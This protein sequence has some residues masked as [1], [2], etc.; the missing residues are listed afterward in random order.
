MK[1]EL[2]FEKVYPHPIERVWRA[3][4]EREALGSWLM[5]TDFVASE[6]HAF[7]MWCEDGEGGTDR[8]LCKVLVLEPQRRMLWSWMLDGK[9]SEGETFVDFRLEEVA[10][11]TRLTV[12]HSGDRDADM[13]E[14]FKGGWPTKLKQ[15]DAALQWMKSAARRA[16]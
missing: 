3:L 1:F 6:G 7:S 11:G 16:R 12:R 4:T 10:S 8:Y 14:K 9:Q 2:D 15:L 13:V 5:E